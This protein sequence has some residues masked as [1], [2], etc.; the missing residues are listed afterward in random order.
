MSEDQEKERQ[1]ESASLDDLLAQVDPLAGSE[2]ARAERDSQEASRDAADPGSSGGGET[3]E[4]GE[5]TAEFAAT[6]DSGE[7]DTVQGEAEKAATSKDPTAAIA[8]GEPVAKEEVRGE[9]SSEVQG[10]RRGYPPNVQRLLDIQLPVT[11]LFG[12]TQKPLEEILKLTPGSVIELDTEPDDPVVLMVN[13]KALAWGRV[14]DVDGYYAVEITEIVERAE[15]I[16]TLG[17]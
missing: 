8:G 3:T 4:T 2:A 15:R 17:G 16:Q 5:S 14:V 7:S 6:A 1:E 11:V 12:S 9:P 13:G 10:A